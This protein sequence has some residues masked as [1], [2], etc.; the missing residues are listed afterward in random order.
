MYTQHV[1]S[2]LSCHHP[3]TIL[4]VGKL[5]KLDC[6]RTIGIDVIDWRYPTGTSMFKSSGQPVHFLAWDFAGQVRIH[7]F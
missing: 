6:D 5:K 3:P 4:D 2:N 1:T 7:V